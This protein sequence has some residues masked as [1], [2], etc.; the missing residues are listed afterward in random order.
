MTFCEF[1]KIGESNPYKPAGKDGLEA[2]HLRPLPPKYSYLSPNRRFAI[3]A[4]ITIAALRESGE[5]L[6]V[7]ARL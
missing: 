1:I 7:P 3:S 2:H 6:P 5:A 4:A